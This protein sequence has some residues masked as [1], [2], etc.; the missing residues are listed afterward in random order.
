MTFNK[1]RFVNFAKY[2]LAINKTFFRNMALVTVI[3]AIGISV[4]MFF[5]RYSAW[6]GMVG[7]DMEAYE[8]MKEMAKGG[9]D[10]SFLMGVPGTYEHFN[11]MPITTLL[12]AEFLGIMIIIFSGCWAHNLRNKQGRIMELT[13]PATNLEKYTW[14]SL[15][16]IGGGILLAFVSLL[17][18]DAFNALF[19]WMLCPASDGFVSLTNNCLSMLTLDFDSLTSL[20]GAPRITGL[21]GIKS[22]EVASSIFTSFK[23]LFWA[24]LLCNLATYHFGNSVKYKYNIILTYVAI[25]VIE[26]AMAIIFSIG[27]A[28]IVSNQYDFDLHPS[29]GPTIVKGFAYTT[30]S[31]FLILSIVL[32]FLSYKRYTKAQI[33]SKLNK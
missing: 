4:A 21:E 2:D 31:I 6:K 27:M 28:F 19:T 3:G 16:T 25:Y 15:L 32:P 9:L 29:D 8:Q 13:I 14:H 18:A 17:C 30:T 5:G 11:T 23:F 1:E 20:F 26:I 33:T 12:L 10:S 7:N 24:A 22:D